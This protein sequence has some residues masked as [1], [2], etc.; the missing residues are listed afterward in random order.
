MW[1][2]I[3]PKVIYWHHFFSSYYCYCCIWKQPRQ[4]F[5]WKTYF[6][7]N[8]WLFSTFLALFDTF[9][10]RY[11]QSFRYKIQ[12]FWPTSIYITIY[13]KKSFENELKGHFWPLCSCQ[14]PITNH[15]YCNAWF[16]DLI[17]LLQRNARNNSPFFQ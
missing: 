12:I 15:L 11:L 13:F 5:S 8:L 7:S 10:T 2:K 16:S 9:T 17:A 3:S 1:E 14:Y 4:I 6:K